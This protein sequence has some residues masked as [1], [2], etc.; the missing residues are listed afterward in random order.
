MFTEALLASLLSICALRAGETDVVD[1]PLSLWTS[2]QW[3]SGTVFG[4]NYG[5]SLGDYDRDGWVDVFNSNTGKLY[6]NL[7]GNDWSLAG[8]LAPKLAPGIR[9]GAAFGDFDGNGYPDLATEPRKSSAGQGDLTL[10]ENSDGTVAGFRNV[11]PNGWRLDVLPFDC[12]T[13]TNNWAD[14]DGDGWVDLFMPTY[15]AGQGSTGNWLLKNRGPVTPNGKCAFTDVSVAAGIKNVPGAD[16]PEGAQF[17]DFDQDGDLDLYCNQV[18]YQNVSTLGKP[19]FRALS[20]DESGILAFGTLDEGAACCDYDMDGDVDL[21]VAWTAPPWATIYENRGDGTFLEDTTLVD[22]PEFF[23]LG[24]GLEDWDLDGDMDWTTSGTFRRNRRIEDGARHYTI[25]TTNLVPGWIGGGLP[26]WFDWDFDGDLDCAYGHY[27]AQARMFRND[28]YDANTPAID[29]RYVRVR[30]LRPSAQ[31]P[32]GL[33]NEFGAT[34]EIELVQGGDGARRV[35]F[36]QTGSGYLNQNEYALNFGLPKT[37]ADLVFNVIVDFP[38]SSGRGI[39]RVDE[40]VNPALGG[41]HLAT[42]VNREIQ[43]LRDGRARIDG[44]EYPP[45]AGV[46]PTLADTAG[47]LALA[48]PGAALVAPVA[49]PFADAWAVLGLST[50]GAS[51]PVVLRQ[52]DL[53]GALDAP[54]GCDGSPANVVVWDVT[55]PAQPQSQAA[56]RLALSTDPRNHRSRLRTNLVLQPGREYRVAARLTTYRASPV[57]ASRSVGGLTVLGSALVQSSSAC[58]ASEIASAPLD[59]GVLYLSARHGR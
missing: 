36:T 24:M 55:D 4:L 35:K 57:Q 58:G 20:K 53:D 54:V 45:L 46:S 50:A 9:Y 52:I 31:L 29:R 28:L 56:H 15:G 2:T 59:A 14:V 32:L 16:R 3:P 23:G 18:L 1:V 47:G 10:L 22:E 27:A 33:D 40:R 8:D 41:I 34:I 51:A 25:A 13:E 11:A 30:P 12:L 43:V 38:V 37:P 19:H 49:T 39:W 21:L 6:R 5:L 7:Q 42:L 44:V 48:A 17:V 26:S